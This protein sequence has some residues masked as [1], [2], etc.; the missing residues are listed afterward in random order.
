MEFGLRLFLKLITLIKKKYLVA[1]SHCVNE[2]LWVCGDMP[3]MAI[4]KR[5][6]ARKCIKKRMKYFKSSLF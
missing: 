2:R 1:D 4:N 5:F 6:Y 3:Y